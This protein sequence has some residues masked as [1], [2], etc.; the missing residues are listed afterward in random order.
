MLFVGVNV[1]FMLFVLITLV[2][3]TIAQ[4]DDILVV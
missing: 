2:S 1:W 4:S 3:N